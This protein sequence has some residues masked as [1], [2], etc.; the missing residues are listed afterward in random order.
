MSS[1]PHLLSSRHFASCPFT[2]IHGL[3]LSPTFSLNLSHFL[4][5]SSFSCI[6]GDISGALIRVILQDTQF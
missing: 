6:F 3:L 2:F 4:E 5:L 1:S